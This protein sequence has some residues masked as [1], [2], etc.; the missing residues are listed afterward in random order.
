[1]NIMYGSRWSLMLLF[2]PSICSWWMPPCGFLLDQF[3]YLGF[4]V[5]VFLLIAVISSIVLVNAL[6]LPCKTNIVP[7]WPDRVVLPFLVHILS[8]VKFSVCAICS[9]VWAFVKSW[10]VINNPADFWCFSEGIDRQRWYLTGNVLKDFLIVPRFT[11]KL[12]LQCNN[13]LV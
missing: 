4:K 2:R 3:W 8:Y 1:M 11:L 6:L 13:I 12:D 9:W 5:W 10:V 7:M